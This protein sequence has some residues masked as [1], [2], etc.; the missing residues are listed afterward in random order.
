MRL[1]A[2]LELL[3][4]VNEPGLDLREPNPQYFSSYRDTW[5]VLIRISGAN[6]PCKSF[7]PFSF[8]GPASKAERI[9]DAVSENGRLFF[10]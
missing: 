1:P 7:G 3:G 8:I 6:V 4:L 5:S 9:A 10:F 2:R